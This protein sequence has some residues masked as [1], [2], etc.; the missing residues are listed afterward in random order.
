M[1]PDPNSAASSS[2]SYAVD[3]P[4]QGVFRTFPQR[5][6]VWSWVRTRGRNWMRTLIHGLRRLM[7]SPWQALT[8]SLR[9]SR[10][11][12]WWWRRMQRLALQL[13]FG[14]C[15][16]A[17]DSSGTRWDGQCGS[18]PTAIGAP[19]HAYGLSFTRKPQP[20]NNSSPRTFLTGAV[21]AASG[22]GGWPGRRERGGEVRRRGAAVQKTVTMVVDVPVLFNDKF[23]QS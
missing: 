9:R 4:F 8:K 17:R 13:A 11:R 1:R 23:P 16:S 6:K 10:R 7:P 22:P 21:V 20:M 18:V 15:E 12:R 2:R 14:L 5:K 3:E 19:S